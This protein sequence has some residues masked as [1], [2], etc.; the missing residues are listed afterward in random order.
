[1]NTSH[2]QKHL[3]YLDKKKRDDMMCNNEVMRAHSNF[4]VT[5]YYNGALVGDICILLSLLLESSSL[6]GPNL[7]PCIFLVWTFISRFEA[8]LLYANRPDLVGRPRRHVNKSFR[9][10]SEHFK[11]SDY[12]DPAE[13]R[14][15]RTAVPSKTVRKTSLKF[16]V[17]QRKN[18][19]LYNPLHTG[20]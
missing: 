15:S 1:M 19:T 10:C 8:W 7:L 20:H 14:L 6:E 16:L 5:E 9:L 17:P 18:K 11:S 2:H 3:A 13:T 12:A 4:W